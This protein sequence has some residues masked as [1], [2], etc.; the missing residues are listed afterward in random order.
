MPI[1]GIPDINAALW[2]PSRVMTKRKCSFINYYIIDDFCRDE[3]T[4][5]C[6]FFDKPVYHFQTL[7]QTF[8]SNVLQRVPLVWILMNMFVLFM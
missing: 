5:A 4:R 1:T 3:T 6:L 2:M 7:H 8:E